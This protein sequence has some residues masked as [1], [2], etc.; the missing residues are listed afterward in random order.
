MAIPIAGRIR[1]DHRLQQDGHADHAHRRPSLRTAFEHLYRTQAA[2][3]RRLENQTT[4]M[5][6]F[7][8]SR[9]ERDTGTGRAGAWTC[10]AG[11]VRRGQ[12]LRPDAHHHHLF[13]A[14]VRIAGSEIESGEIAVHV[15]E[16]KQG[17]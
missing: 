12:Q 14:D 3:R 17:I 13:N 2:H 10:G 8:A 16:T 1:N 9:A 5:R 7:S 4:A 11:G 6:A 15:E